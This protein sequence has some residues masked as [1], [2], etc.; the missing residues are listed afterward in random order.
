METNRTT[1]VQF[2]LHSGQRRR[3]GSETNPG[4]PPESDTGTRSGA[5]ISGYDRHRRCH[6]VPGSGEPGRGDCGA[7]EPGNEAALAGARN[8][9]GDPL[10]ARVRRQTSADRVRRPVDRREVVVARTAGALERLE[11]GTP[12]GHRLGCAIS[13]GQYL[14]KG[15]EKGGELWQKAFDLYVTTAVRVSKCGMTAIHIT[16]IVV[17]RSGMHTIPIQNASAASGTTR[18]TSVLIAVR[19]SWSIQ[20]CRMNI[21]PGANQRTW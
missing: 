10:S 8:S 4:R 5:V 12:S 21:A 15:S 20:E 18:H 13:A 19:N 7:T 9:A 2:S 1:E 3:P 6:E 17:E 16:L 14:R 11:E